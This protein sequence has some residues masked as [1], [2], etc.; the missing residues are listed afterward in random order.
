[1]SVNASS[2]LKL[3]EETSCSSWLF[4][5]LC[6]KNVQHVHVVEMTGP[7]CRSRSKFN[8][9]YCLLSGVLWEQAAVLCQQTQRSHEGNAR[10]HLTL[11]QSDMSAMFTRCLCFHQSKGAKEKVVTRIMVSRCEVDL[12]KIR[13]EFKRQHKK[14]LYQTIA[15]SHCSTH[16]DSE[17]T[18][19]TTHILSIV[20]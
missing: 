12:M 4:G 16:C 1:M 18:H 9:V 7:S 19:W 17:H 20:L 3:C 5:T 13:S 2:W 6:L 15:V 11:Q 8:L 14:S 10:P